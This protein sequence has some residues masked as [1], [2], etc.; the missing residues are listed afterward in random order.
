MPTTGP[1]L[2]GSDRQPAA[3]GNAPGAQS[4]HGSSTRG[5]TGRKRSGGWTSHDRP[6][7]SRT[8]RPRLPGSAIA[9]IR[10]RHL[11]RSWRSSTSASPA[12][13]RS[14]TT[15]SR[16][17]GQYALG[18]PG[19]R[20]WAGPRTASWS[21]TRTRA[22]SGQSVDGRP[23][24]QRLLAEVGLDHVGLILGLEM[25]RL[26][27]SCKDWHQLLELCGRLPHA[28]GR[29][30]RRLRPDRPQRPAPAGPEELHEIR[31]RELHIA[32]RSPR[33]RPS[34][35]AAAGDVAHR[36]HVELQPLRRPEALR[37]QH[38][39][40]RRIVMCRQAARGSARPR[41]PASSGPTPRPPA[42]AP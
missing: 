3:V 39:C 40:D 2:A 31:H 42:A 15:G 16:A 36:V 41:P 1:A 37:V 6:R 32:L 23:G 21:S 38:L 11:D 22:S 24:F 20:P 17:S 7:V 8:A 35:A 26:A 4:G 28:A 25:S 5:T 18:R 30:G 19:R 10:D 34:P 9:K 13:S 27:R 29:P 14:S 12:P 33:R